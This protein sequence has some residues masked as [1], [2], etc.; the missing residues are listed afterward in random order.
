MTRVVGGKEIPASA[1]IQI[2]KANYAPSTLFDFPVGGRQHNAQESEVKMK[3]VLSRKIGDISP[4][5][6]GG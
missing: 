4:P 1:G 6:R 3:S 2:S 5:L